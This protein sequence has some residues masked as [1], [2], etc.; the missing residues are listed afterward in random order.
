MI[1]DGWRSLAPTLSEAL[2]AGI[3]E[4]VLDGR[5]R[6]TDRLPAERQ[7][8]AE[9]GLSRGT[10][11]AAFASLRAGGWL[12][13]R[14]GS[15]STVRIPAALRLRYAPLSVD[16]PGPLL[17]LRR[18]LPAAP[19]DAYTAAVRGALA[20][21]PRLLLEAGEPGPGLPEL[22]ELIAGRFTG[23]G[24]PTRPEQIL[25]TAGARAA[26]TLLAAH[27]RPRA[28]VVE[29][30][31]FDGILALLRR[32]GR[33]LVPVTVTPA[34]WDGGQLRAAFGRASGGIALLVPDFHNPT[35]AL[36]ATQTRNELA[37][38]AAGTGV[39]VIANETP[40]DLDLRLPPEPAPRI[41]GAVTIGS[42]SKTVWGGLRI[43]W[44]RG[45]G[46]LIRELL[47]NPLCVVCAPPPMEQLIACGLLPRL[48]LLIAQRASEL[49][50]QRDH[51]AAALGGNSA[52]T[53]TLPPG[54]LWLWLRLSGVSGD[55]LATRA[56]ASGLAL[57]PGSRF[58][59]DGTHRGWLRLPYTAP[60]ETLDKAA[61]LLH[62]AAGRGL[63]S[64][65]EHG[66]QRRRS[67][68][69]RAGPHDELAVRAV[70]LPARPGTAVALHRD[71]RPELLL[72]AGLVPEPQPQAV[73]GLLAPEPGFAPQ[74]QP[75]LG[76]GAELVDAQCAG[77]GLIASRAAGLSGAHDDLLDDA[78][79]QRAS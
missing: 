5:I 16:H 22:R 51:L 25:I 24:L 67:F 40:R 41:P 13:T 52:W 39:T 32:P 44:I 10:V 65:V 69:C 60:L 75:P 79:R 1:R 64:G 7:L 45:P 27:F 36:M 11:A 70:H 50:R 6:G 66:L 20:R 37:T 19:H 56:A 46:R 54:G 12:A 63:W 59:Q 77:D 4:A 71:Q 62:E 42:L 58:T 18:A 15:G 73:R 2:A 38:L 31:T 29:S 8:A 74:P 28:A 47:L 48:E 68:G 23:Q 49:R 30:P 3:R 9:L 72:G 17:D 55:E 35:G 33:R 34:G 61:A 57:I 53:F 76:L 78:C 14:H 43:G 26:I 21:S